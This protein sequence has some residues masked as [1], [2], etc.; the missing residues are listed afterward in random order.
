MV[1]LGNFFISLEK[2]SGCSPDPHKLS[3]IPNEH[4]WCLYIA[5]HAMT[6]ST[7]TTVC[8]IPNEHENDAYTSPIMSW[9]NMGHHKWTIVMFRHLQ[10][11]HDISHTNC[12]TSKMNKVMLRHHHG[13][14]KCKYQS[15]HDIIHTNMRHHKW[16]LVML[17]HLHSCHDI[18]HTKML[19]QIMLRHTHNNAMSK[20]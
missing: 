9:G 7:L 6:S 4:K 14:A 8:D 10:S 12:A 16:T 3:D 15:C 18:I 17:R 1:L 19:M 20:Y 11:C 5:N 13:I 2:I